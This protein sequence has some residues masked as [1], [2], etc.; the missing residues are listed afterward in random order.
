MGNGQEVI[1]ELGKFHGTS[2][3]GGGFCTLDGWY[4]VI[5]PDGQV[6][7]FPTRAIRE[8]TLEIISPLAD[9]PQKVKAK[10]IMFAFMMESWA[11]AWGGEYNPSDY[12][13]EIW[14]AL[15]VSYKKRKHFVRCFNL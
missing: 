6:E 7:V 8:S 9:N 3:P 14:E 15:D 5:F 12:T 4:D 1:V 2:P 11:Q 10:G 13:S